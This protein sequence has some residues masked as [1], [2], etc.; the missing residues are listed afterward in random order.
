[1]KAVRRNTSSG[2]PVSCSPV[3]AACSAETGSPVP[4]YTAEKS[5]MG[6]LAPE[7]RSVMSFPCQV[8]SIRPHMGVPSQG[9]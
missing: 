8:R 1:M 6:P 9:A 5:R 7:R 3:S 2:R 4:V